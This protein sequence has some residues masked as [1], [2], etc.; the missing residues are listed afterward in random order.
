MLWTLVRKELLANLLTYRLTVTLIFTVVLSALT[1]IIGSMDYSRNMAAYHQEV[2]NQ[3]EQLDQA[4]VYQQV[5]PQYHFAAA[6]A[7]HFCPRGDGPGPRAI[8]R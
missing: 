5:A 1:T 6:T 8:T 7:G 4:T 2:R 3:Q